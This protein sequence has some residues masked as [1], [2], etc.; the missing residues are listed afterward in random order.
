MTLIYPKTRNSRFCLEKPL[1]SLIVSRYSSTIQTCQ[2]TPTAF[3]CSIIHGR[4]AQMGLGKEATII[5]AIISIPKQFYLQ[6]LTPIFPRRS[7]TNTTPRNLPHHLTYGLIS[8]F[9]EWLVTGGT[10]H[11]V[12]YKSYPSLRGITRALRDTHL[13]QP[14]T[15]CPIF[16]KFSLL[17]GFQR[18][19]NGERADMTLRGRRYEKFIPLRKDRS[20]IHHIPL[21]HHHG[22]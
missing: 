5:Q 21:N 22:S 16:L 18:V 9:A 3:G 17:A 7:D 15:L 12:L 4:Y 13:V 20:Y 11:K 10:L 1:L 19:F 14:R 6:C 2:A 8:P